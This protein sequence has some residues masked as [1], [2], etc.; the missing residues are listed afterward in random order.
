M[1]RKE[2]VLAVCDKV[3]QDLKL[4]ELALDG[5]ATD[6]TIYSNIK[7]MWLAELGL[8]G[9]SPKVMISGS[10]V[11]VFRLNIYNVPL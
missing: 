5:S 6:G 1:S 7:E 8:C 3:L 2:Q 10:F 4:E 11:I 9:P